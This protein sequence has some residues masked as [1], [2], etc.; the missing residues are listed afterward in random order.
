MAPLVCGLGLLTIGVWLALALAIGV[1][2]T[3][4]AQVVL[5]ANKIEM[6]LIIRLLSEATPEFVA[7]A[8]LN[9]QLLTS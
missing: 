8:E 6:R 2:T 4:A 7:K 3:N 9:V 1:P 5:A